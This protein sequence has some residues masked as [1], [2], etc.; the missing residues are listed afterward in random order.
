MLLVGFHGH[1]GSGKNFAAGQMRLR[2]NNSIELAYAQP[3]KEM[4]MAGLSL[5]EEQLNTDL[6][7]VSDE[8]YGASPR[9]LMQ[10]LGTEWGR[11]MVSDYIW[12]QALRSK[13]KN[14]WDKNAIFV[15]DV[16]F[17][18][19]A[20]LIRDMGGTVVHIHT[21]KETSDEHSSENQ[22]PVLEEDIL[23]INKFDSSFI[24]EIKKV[25]YLLVN[26]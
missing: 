15:T 22:L 4:L 7:E 24:D 3:L 13:I 12:V 11:G 16:R 20:Q 8:R 21:I 6:K 1:K 5:T 14:N 10:S 26:K 2:S 19:E 25:F 18:N 9:E 17:P 23:V